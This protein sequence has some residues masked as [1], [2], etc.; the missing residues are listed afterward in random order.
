MSFRIPVEDAYCALLG[1]AI[2]IFAYYELIVIKIVDHFSPGYV[3]QYLVSV[4][5]SRAIGET[6]K[7]VIQKSD[8]SDTH[9]RLKL[10]TEAER[11]LE[12]VDDRNSLLHFHPYSAIS[13]E[14][15]FLEYRS[16]AH[17][18]WDRS[19]IRKAIEEFEEGSIELR[20]L[21]RKLKQP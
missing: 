13:G 6:L 15:E 8:L 1:R 11:F 19:V 5:T 17:I 2:Y 3:E 9:L 20:N 7:G 4:W 16:P 21:F 12:L 14:Q 10:E 18:Q